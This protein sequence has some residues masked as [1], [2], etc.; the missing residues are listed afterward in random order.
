MR[1]RGLTLV[2]ILVA[3]ALL[4]GILAVALRYFVLQAEQTRRIQAR[5][6]V[7]ERVRMVMEIVSQDLLLAGNQ[8][9]ISSES[10]KI[11]LSPPYLSATDGQSKDTFTVK[12]VTSLRQRGSACRVVS[13]SFS[14]N[15]LQRRDVTCDK[16]NDSSIGAQPLADEIL[17][18]DI[19]Y[20]CSSLTTE[21]SGAPPCPAGSYPR[22]AR[23][24]VVGRS[25]AKVPGSTFPDPQLANECKDYVCFALEQEV[26]LP[27]LKDQ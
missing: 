3:I 23:V 12:Y 21:T 6:E 26:L 15:T 14:G 5:N 11:Y 2:E 1:P 4:T 13:Y 20:V 9:F 24:R 10:E 8:Y 25:L 19:T 18:L 17:V 27:N 7:Q 16:E 22:S